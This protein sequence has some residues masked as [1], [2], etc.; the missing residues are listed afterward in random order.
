M[1]VQE[2]LVLLLIG[3]TAGL[4][5]GMFGIGGGVIMVPALV[6]FM[7]MN[8]HNAQG[9]SIAL[10]LLPIGILA[11]HNYYKAG[12]LNI[13]YGLIIA[14]AFVIG[15]YF[16][17]KFSLGISEPVL[18]RAFGVLMLIISVKIIFFDK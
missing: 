6:I 12:S 1:K 16:G 15:G 11:A 13:K 17:S 7:G 2:I 8:Q 10:M 18:K 5:S 9:T 4:L 3:F 14:F